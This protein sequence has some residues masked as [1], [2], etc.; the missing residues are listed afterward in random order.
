MSLAWFRLYGET[1]DDAKLRL[2]AFEDRWHYIAILCCK[3]QGIL[4][5][6]KPELLDRTVAAKLGLA[7]RELD[8]VRRRLIEVDLIHQDWQPAGW[9]RRQYTSDD[10]TARVRRFREKQ[11]AASEKEE[12]IPKTDTDTERV[13]TE[14]LRETLHETLPTSE[15][16][17]WLDHRK[18]RRWPCDPTT[19]TKQLN[20]LKRF[21]REEQIEM[22][23]TS[24]NS[25]WQGLFAPKGSAPKARKTRYAQLMEPL[26]DS[27]RTP[28]LPAP[29]VFG[30]IKV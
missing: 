23:D 20:L 18:R 26:Q 28:A 16:R 7:L 29:S 1:V 14:T 17:E 10:S 4:D 25:G 8:E 2:L 9:E 15:W 5:N 24:I 6:T 27:A 22:I 3:A 13:V 11:S 30:E 12:E 19:L 21:S